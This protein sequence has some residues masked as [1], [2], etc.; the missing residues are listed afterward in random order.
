MSVNR[1]ETN[2]LSSA[3]GVVG[4]GSK[5]T[6]PAGGETQ[7]G[8][9]NVSQD[10]IGSDSQ[11]LEEFPE[12]EKSPEISR[13]HPDRPV[14][15][16]LIDAAGAIFAELGPAATVRQICSAAGCSVAAV[17]YHFGDKHQLYVRCVQAAC[18]RKQ[19][20]FPLP[21]LDQTGELP[22][23]LRSFLRAV[24]SRM[25]ASSNVSWHNTLMLREVISPSEGVAEIL[26]KPFRRDI[27]LLSELVA[28]LLGSE[29][30]SEDLRHALV[31]QI[32]ARCMFL[33]TGKSFRSMVEINQPENDD[34]SKYADVICNS[35]L[36]QIDSLRQLKKLPPLVWSAHDTSLNDSNS[37]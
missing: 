30:D 25:A 1:V 29:L 27:G 14:V 4:L 15:D 3:A 37:D 33:R 13:D 11:G 36:M 17:N 24:N 19:R 32:V 2:P 16:R 21:N 9:G 28:R 26:K 23:L 8:G 18:E 6:S 35:I 34:P 22:E 12:R 20:L 31:T 7:S 5:L 10:R